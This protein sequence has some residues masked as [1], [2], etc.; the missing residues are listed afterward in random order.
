MAEVSI[1]EVAEWLDNNSRGFG[2]QVKKLRE[3]EKWALDQQPVKVGDRAVMTHRPNTDNGWRYCREFLVPGSTGF[4]R[5]V[6]LSS[7]GYWGLL[8]QPEVQWGVY[9]ARESSRKGQLE[10]RHGG[11]QS[12]FFLKMAWVRKAKKKDKPLEIPADSRPWRE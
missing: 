10:R 5:E 1:D 8:F 4:V 12:C 2:G 3:I 7:D 6:Y 11:R 9:D